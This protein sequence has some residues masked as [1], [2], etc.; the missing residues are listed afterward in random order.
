M[1]PN[2]KP[3]IVAKPMQMSLDTIP[4]SEEAEMAT[5]GAILINPK[6][7]PLI[8]EFLRAEDFYFLRNQYIFE[9]MERLYNKQ[10]PIDYVTLTNE[11][12]AHGQLDEIGGATYITRLVN[13]PPDSTK[14]RFYAQLVSRTAE[15]RRMLQANDANRALILDESIPVEQKR[16]MLL[17]QLEQSYSHDRLLHESQMQTVVSDYLDELAIKVEE[18]GKFGVPSGYKNIDD[19]LKGF[20]P[21]EVTYL[22]GFPGMGKTLLIV[23]MVLRLGRMGVPVAF[24]SA[25]M[26][27]AEVI[28]R[29]LALETGIDS[30][31]IING[32]LEQREL[33]RLYESAGRIAELPIRIIENQHLTPTQLKYEL[34]VL[35]YYYGVKIAFVDG[36]WLMESDEEQRGFVQREF[37]KLG[38]ITLQLR[39]IARELRVPLVV[40]HQY[41]HEMRDR[42]NKVPQQTDMRG[43]Q[44]VAQNAHVI[45]GMMDG[46]HSNTADP[47]NPKPENLLELHV[48][49]NRTGKGGRVIQLHRDLERQRID[50]WEQI[51]HRPTGGNEWTS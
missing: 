46:T 30:N 14:A 45:L 11:I 44:P 35:R 3:K 49:K 8:A 16:P 28:D 1:K 50:D 38:K 39:E 27:R 22:A 2:A 19:V 33:G 34:A 24:F 40:A 13:E 48:L 5:I 29:L 37:E 7:M 18:R 32:D 42:Q 4:Q 21:G 36:L 17:H 41:N 6:S 43:G 25:E 9:A 20:K 23:N 47:N 12:E 10:E 15:L 31:A 51:K 26:S